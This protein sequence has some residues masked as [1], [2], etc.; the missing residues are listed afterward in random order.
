M[1]RNTYD[2]SGRQCSTSSSSSGL[3][4]GLVSLVGGVGLGAGLLY[5]LDPEQGEKRRRRMYSTAA[6]LASTAGG[7]MGNVGS[8]LGSALGSARDYASEKWDDVRGYASDT[9][10]DAGRYASKRASGAASGIRGFFGDRT[11]DA[12]KFIQRQTFGET[13]EEHRLGV[14]ICALGSMALG[15][16]IMYTLDPTMGASRRRYAR[17]KAGEMASGASEYARQASDA[18]RTGID[19]AKDKVSS[20][21]SGSGSGSTT[22]AGGANQTNTGQQIPP[23][24]YASTA[25]TYNPSNPTRM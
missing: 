12:R 20:M 21:T 25:S 22:A 18:I 8:T 14:T 1:R 9:A 11:D 2:Q 23:S 15:A 10:D 6:D 4:T 7:A 17:E 5:L 19:Q 3:L 24:G 16:A 13:R